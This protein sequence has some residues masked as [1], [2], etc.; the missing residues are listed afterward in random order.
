MVLAITNE[1][2]L[3]LPMTLRCGGHPIV[4]NHNFLYIMWN[5]NS[6]I[7]FISFTRITSIELD[8]TIK[9]KTECIET[10]IIVGSF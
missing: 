5:K 9:N 7:Q 1:L 2:K 6:F 10:F 8:C 4:I 3:K